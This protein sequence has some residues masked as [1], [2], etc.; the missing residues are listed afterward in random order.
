MLLDKVTLPRK[1][2]T[3]AQKPR[4]LELDPKLALKKQE[5]AEPQFSHPNHDEVLKQQA[6]CGRAETLTAKGKIVFIISF[7]KDVFSLMFEHWSE[8]TL[9]LPDVNHS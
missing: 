2:S 4:T 9:Q 7:I 5:A 6:T 3:E 1:D 8:Y